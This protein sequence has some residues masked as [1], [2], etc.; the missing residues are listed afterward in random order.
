MSVLAAK[1]HGRAVPL[2]QLQRELFDIPA[3]DLTLL[4][5]RLRD[6]GSLY[7]QGEGWA[8]RVPPVGADI[9]RANAEVARL[10]GR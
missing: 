4:L 7:E 6:E 3:P 1:N 10:Q 9:V 5:A 2:A 8:P